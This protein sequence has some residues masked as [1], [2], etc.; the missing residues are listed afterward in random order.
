[1]GGTFKGGTIGFRDY[2]FPRIGRTVLGVPIKKDSSI[3]GC[4]L[5]FRSFG[6][7]P[8]VYMHIDYIELSKEHIGLRNI[9]HSIHIEKNMEHEME[10][11]TT[12]YSRF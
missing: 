9:F 6:K 7:L 1:M 8:H 10:A 4:I 3:L 12:I 2:A 11:T 5:G